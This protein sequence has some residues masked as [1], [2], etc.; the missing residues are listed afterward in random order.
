MRIITSIFF[1]VYVGFI[2][3]QI[4][5]TEVASPSGVGLSCGDTFLGNGITFHDYDN[6]GWDDL[7]INTDGSSALR[8]F[9][10][11]NGVFSQEFLL[12]PIE[13][14]QSKQAN[15]VDIDNDGD[16][17]LF[18]TSDTEMVRLYENTGNMNFQD[19]TLT[20]GFP[21]VNMYSYGASW[22]DYNNDGYLDVFI[23]NRDEVTYNIPNFL[24]RN[25]GDG[26]F[27]NVTV[28]AGLVTTANSSFCSAFFDFNND[29]WQDIF[30]ANDRV[31]YP[32]FLYKNNGDGTF[33]EVGASSG[34]GLYMNAMSATVDDFNHDG[35]FDLYITNTSAGNVFLMNNGD[36]TFSD[37]TASTGTAFNGWGWGAVFLDVENDADLDLYVSGM[38]SFT[39]INLIPYAFYENN[40]S[41][42]FSQ[43]AATGFEIDDESSFSNAIGDINKD[44]LIDIVV[45]NDEA[46]DIF[47]WK[48][49]TNTNNNWLKVRLQGSVSNR[50]GIGSVI[51][52][53]INGNKQYRYTLCGEGYL[54]QNSQTEHFGIG[55][56]TSVD[57]IKVSWLS[58][59][60]DIL[61]NIPA[62]QEIQL[63]EGTAPLSADAFS[64]ERLDIFPNPTHGLLNVRADQQ[65]DKIEIYNF[66]GQQ[67]KSFEITGSM[68]A[69]L[70]LS[71]LNS[72][73]Y[74]LKISSSNGLKQLRQIIKN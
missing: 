51:E 29:G 62:N 43:P 38:L 53:G 11:V 55:L 2:H 33:T 35:W 64:D 52:I 68:E 42:I 14:Y 71:P 49:E 3:A 58:G 63:T 47:L 37:I 41:G 69:S 73:I 10:N 21:T 61:Y 28:S 31:V 4:T 22:G 36:E 67:V 56:N 23:S 32:N 57:Y 30:V 12:L 26:T 25:N 24:Y 65:I 19:I 34:A 1:L 5:F 13:S 7:T 46:S 15:W 50:D 45:A 16:K 72:G 17:D 54:S 6:D 44:G 40:N 70:D 20:A 8:F 60:V 48:N 27:T 18:V 74:I 59:I 66:L 9:R 39:N